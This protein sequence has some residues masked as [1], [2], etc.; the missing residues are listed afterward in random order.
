MY[1][2][3]RPTYIIYYVPPSTV[4]TGMTLGTLAKFPWDIYIY[5]MVWAKLGL[6]L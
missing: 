4:A 6:H 5:I 2:N 3:N 1:M